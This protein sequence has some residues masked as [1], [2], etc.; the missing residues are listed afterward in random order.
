MHTPSFARKQMPKTLLKNGYVVTVD[1]KRAVYPDGFVAIDGSTITATGPGS[2]A[3]DIAQFDEVIDASGCIVL[4]G[5]INMH[6]HHWY[7]LFKGLADGY[8]L[9]DWVG[10]FLLPLAHNMT[11]QAMRVSSAIA[12]MEM[13]ATGTTCSL[14]HSV[15]TTTPAMV[16]ATIEPQAELGLRQVFGKEL[17]C[18]TPGNP[19]HPLSLDESL[20]A[21][22]EETRR[23]HGS[24]NGR[25][26]FAAT[27][28]SNAHWVAAGMSTEELIT[29]G[30]Q[31]MKKL[32][33][34][35]TDH[36]AG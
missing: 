25:V 33:L 12:G 6:Q 29:R 3:P 19:K 22:E 24:S 34:R 15:T 13:L 2:S 7:T 20:A 1:A 36:I 23:W 17:R 28:E 4:P 18:N 32:D 21:F 14:N 16:A 35:I 8:L 10:G 9:E 31:L 5:L 26:R 30:Y 27:I 11:D